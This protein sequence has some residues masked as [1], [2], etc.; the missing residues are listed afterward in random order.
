MILVVD[1]IEAARNELVGRGAEVS[2]IWHQGPRRRPAAGRRPPSVAPTSAGRPSRTRTAISGSCRR[3]PSASRGGCEQMDVAGRA[4]LLHETSL[5]HGSV[6][7]RRPT[8]R[9]VGLVCGVHGRSQRR[10]R[11]GRRR[12]EREPVHGRGEAGRSAVMNAIDSTHSNNGV[13]AQSWSES[14]THLKLERR[15]PA[16]GG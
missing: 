13:A 16:T 6:R 15:S 9:L 10:E 5:R 3:S 14:W 4:Q 12:G 1:D 2:E 11:P 7:G 8:A